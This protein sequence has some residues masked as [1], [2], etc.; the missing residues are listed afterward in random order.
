M[1][2]GRESNSL[3]LVFVCAPCIGQTSLWFNYLCS[4]CIGQ[5]FLWFNYLCSPCIGQ[6]SLWFNYFC[7]VRQNSVMGSVYPFLINCLYKTFLLHRLY[8]S[9]YS[10][11]SFYQEP[12]KYGIISLAIWSPVLFIVKC[13]SPQGTSARGQ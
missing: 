13:Y 5:T 3:L 1:T 10:S 7:C 6:T 9:D 4:P 11:V 12:A 8:S 2:C